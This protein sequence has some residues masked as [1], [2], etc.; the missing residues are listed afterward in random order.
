MT[1]VQA[2]SPVRADGRGTV[3]HSRRQLL[4]DWVVKRG[5]LFA[6]VTA[7]L[8]SLFLG[9]LRIATPRMGYL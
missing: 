9:L 7:P 1:L 8:A 6:L 3:A 2:G 5:V 4:C